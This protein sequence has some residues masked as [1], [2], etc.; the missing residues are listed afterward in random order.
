MLTLLA[1]DPIASPVHASTPM[2]KALLLFYGPWLAIALVGVAILV[3]FVVRLNRA[4]KRR[5]EPRDQQRP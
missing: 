1:Q 3:V 2:W 4:S 5:S